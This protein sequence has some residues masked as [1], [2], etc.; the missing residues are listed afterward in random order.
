MIRDSGGGWLGGFIVNLGIGQ[1]LDAEFWGMFL[2]I[3]LA[4]DKRVSKLIIETDSASMVQLMTEA[5]YSNPLAGVISSFRELMNQF[6]YCVLCHIYRETNGV[7]DCL[8]KWSY[9][10][11]LG[12]YTFDHVPTWVDP[13]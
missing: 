4:I 13:F 6:D 5:L 1:I 7:A 8:A 10:M 3:R 9:N 11:D 2:G 12:L